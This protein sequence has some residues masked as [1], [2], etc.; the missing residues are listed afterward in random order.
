MCIFYLNNIATCNRVVLNMPD[1]FLSVIISAHI[2]LPLLLP[3]Y[4]CLGINCLYLRYID[5]FEINKKPFIVSIRIFT[6]KMGKLFGYQRIL[7]FRSFI[8]N[9]LAPHFKNFSITFQIFLQK[10]SNI[11]NLNLT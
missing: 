1:T 10:R 2:N 11:C 7:V 4:L 5:W 3:T 9:W 6:L 8:L